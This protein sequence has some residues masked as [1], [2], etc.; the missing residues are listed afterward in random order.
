[1]SWKSTLFLT[2]ALCWTNP[3]FLTAGMTMEPLSALEPINTTI[4]MEAAEAVE[5]ASYDIEVNV[6]YATTVEGD[7]GVPVAGAKVVLK[8]SDALGRRTNFR[9]GVTDDNGVVVFTYKKSEI[10]NPLFNTFLTAWVTY[11]LAA[12][13]LYKRVPVG[14]HEQVT[15]WAPK[16][17][18][19]Y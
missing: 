6:R 15:F 11:D 8:V 13:A 1:M 14:S 17:A 7:P 10:P 12:P 19:R 3:A 4:E 18:D 9:S 5:E 16:P 2:M